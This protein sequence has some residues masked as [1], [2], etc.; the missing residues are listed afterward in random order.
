MHACVCLLSK[1]PITTHRLSNP[2]DDCSGPHLTLPAAG[3]T[4][5]RS[6]NVVWAPSPPSHALLPGEVEVVRQLHVRLVHRSHPP[7][8]QV[9]ICI[10]IGLRLRMI[11]CVCVFE[12]RFWCDCAS[13]TNAWTACVCMADISAGLPASSMAPHRN[14]RR[15]LCGA[16]GCWA[17][18]CTRHAEHGVPGHG[19]K[20]ANGEQW[21]GVGAGW[22]CRAPC[23]PAHTLLGGAYHGKSAA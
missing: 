8:L 1:T 11:V 23:T 21:H 10:V 15:H 22:V 20:A 9:R 12:C 4:P 19:A 13:E 2:W 7:E 17:A 6:A 3:H 14:Q 5:P 18:A 16:G